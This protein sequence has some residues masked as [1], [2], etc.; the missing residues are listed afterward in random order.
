M[1]RRWAYLSVLIGALLCGAAVAAGGPQLRAVLLIAIGSAILIPLTLKAITGSLDPLEPLVIA[2]AAFAILYLARPV[3]DALRG[4]VSYLSYGVDAT[5]DVALASVA[6]AVIAFQF[7]Y[8]A[9]RLPRSAAHAVRRVIGVDHPR[10]DI[11]LMGSAMALTALGAGAALASAVLAGGAD[12]LVQ[13]RSAIATG[14]TNIP[15][16]AV[17]VSFT[18]PGLLLLSCVEGRAKHLARILSLLPLAVLGI[19]AIPKGDR[20]LLLPLIVAIGAFFY[21]RRGRRPSLWRISVAVAAVFF[22]IITPLREFRTGQ[23]TLGD[24]VVRT[25]QNPGA[26]AADLLIAQDTSQVSVMALLISQVG[27]DRAIPWQWGMAT[28]TETLLQPVPRQLWSDKP[29]PIRTQFIEYN[30][31]MA[32]GRCVS[33]CPTLSVVGTFYADF[34]LL[35]VA[36]GC[37]AL[38]WFAR[39]WYLLMMSMRTDAIAIAAYSGTLSTF[40][41]VWWSNLGAAV[42]DFGL[43][44]IPVVIVGV[45]ARSRRRGPAPEA[46]LAGPYRRMSA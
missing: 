31:G 9:P 12:L 44:A 8:A 22:L 27:D 45:L 38:G 3:Y 40:F 46:A 34:G 1:D 7:G 6:I 14:A 21:L 43:Y 10:N 35:G 19:T 29:E 11:V 13:D 20:R 17:A 36:L 33:Q 18:V 42:V 23:T 24:A 5:Y 26:A 16:V 15:I 30:W 4:D 28:L 25:I 39:V 41:F 2:S 32:R 37:L